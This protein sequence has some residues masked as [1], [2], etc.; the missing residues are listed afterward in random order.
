MD[1]GKHTDCDGTAEQRGKR[2]VLCKT[3]GSNTHSSGS[4]LNREET[5]AS[6]KI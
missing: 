1:N 5:D 6:P 4:L 3:L 2:G